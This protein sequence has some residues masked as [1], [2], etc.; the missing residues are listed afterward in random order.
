[1][2][3]MNKIKLLFALISM[4][5]SSLTLA[6]ANNEFSEYENATLT[7]NYNGEIG[8][9]LQ[10]VAKELNV[11]FISYDVNINQPLELDIN[12]NMTV[13]TFLQ[14]LMNSMP[15][16]QISFKT[17]GS[18]PFLVFN[19]KTSV[20]VFDGS[21]QASGVKFEGK[22]AAPAS[23]KVEKKASNTAKNKVAVKKSNTT[24]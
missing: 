4:S 1:M 19:S 21:P 5:A 14:N 12:H 10:Q 23:A 22:P 16:S 11:G 24:K 6:Q 17:I 15:S 8:T 13:K 9:L 2:K 20:P 3:K 7:I 18:L